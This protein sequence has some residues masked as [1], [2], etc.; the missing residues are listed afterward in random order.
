[1][2]IQRTILL[3]AF[4]VISFF[5]WNTWQAEHP[6]STSAVVNNSTLPG[7]SDTASS[8]SAANSN[9]MGITSSEASGTA[10]TP[11]TKAN[12]PVLSNSNKVNANSNQAHFVTVK[13]D[14]LEAQIDLKGGDLVSTRLLEYPQSLKNKE[15][16]V[17]LLAPDGDQYYVAQSALINPNGP[18]SLTDRAVYRA[19]Q[20][21]Y[22]LSDNQ[23]SLQVV[24][25][26]QNQ[27]GL[28][29][30]KIYQF[31]RG[32]YLVGVKYQIENQGKTTWQGSLYTQL[33]R[34]DPSVS[35]SKGL[36][37]VHP[38]VGAAVS[39]PDERYQEISFKKMAEDNFDQNITNGWSAMVEH[40]FLTAW[41]PDSFNTNRYFTKA[42]GDQVYTV[43]MQSPMI[44][45]APGQ[46]QTVS[47]K[48]YTG[49]ERADWLQKIA[50]GLELTVSYGW[51]W[52]ISVAIFWLM[53]WINVVVANWGWSI[54]LVTVLIKLIF[55]PLS[56][57]SY[58]SM[59]NMKKVQPKIEELKQKFGDD[60][61][62]FSQAMMQLYR[63]EKVNP[64]GG[65]LP[66]LIQIPVFFALYMV[67]IE[68]VQFRQAPW[69]FW[70]HDLS[71]PDPFYVLP[72]LMG[73]TMLI[74][75]KLNPP[76]PDPTQAK[77]MMILPVVFTFLFANFP[78]GLVLY[79]V[80]NNA[81]SILQ[82]WY[83]TQ[84]FESKGKPQIAKA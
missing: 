54:V 55:Y 29:V 25:Q 82:Q 10:A 38:Y 16:S 1:M 57:K 14:V 42:L 15:N 53:K 26:W 9:N 30:N 28:M 61:Q 34:K 80:V 71:T 72:V 76:P 37:Q 50:P 11:S 19:K 12:L 79:W 35:A 56:A 83:V 65:C 62:Q 81:L 2:E 75:Q 39:S 41:V 51:L 49:P 21:N 84:K 48:L 7:N 78:S 68:S 44:Q 47:A 40:Y 20:Q 13:T 46:T 70:I 5:L 67:L 58:R 63:T 3:T 17:Q 33:T 43:G 73:L 32:E 23:D 52:P 74:Q 22:V 31:K 27:Q 4:I 64:L 77:M 59:A 69:I 6:V 18:D 24:L 60:K 66:I 36:F 45:V 8:S